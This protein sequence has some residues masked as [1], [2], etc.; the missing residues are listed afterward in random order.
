RHADRQHHHL[1]HGQRLR[2]QHIVFEP[3]PA[4]TA[5]TNY[6][7]TV[8]TTGGGP[9]TYTYTVRPFDATATLPGVNGDF[10]ANGASDLLFQNVDGR[11]AIWLMNGTAPTATQEIIGAATG[12]TVR[13]VAH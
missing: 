12:W 4:I 10:N 11:Q 13:L 8:T 1:E 5:G 3:T 9:G 6:R 7:V 2:R